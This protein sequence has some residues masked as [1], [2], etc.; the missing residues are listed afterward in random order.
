MKKSKRRE[1]QKL[2]LLEENY[3]LREQIP[4][5]PNLERLQMEIK[6]VGYHLSDYSRW[7]LRIRPLRAG[8]TD[9]ILITFHKPI[10]YMNAKKLIAEAFGDL[11]NGHS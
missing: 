7:S 6:S 3:K 8:Y 11:E 5:N 9:Q 4:H 2:R 1:L 10:S